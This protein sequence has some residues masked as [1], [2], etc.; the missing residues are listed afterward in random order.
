MNALSPRA[1]T[2]FRS[3]FPLRVLCAALI[4]LGAS[5]ADATDYFVSAS[6]ADAH[7][8]T[9][10]ADAWRTVT[11]VNNQ[12][13]AAGDRVFFEGGQTFSGNLYLDASEQGTAAAPIVI[14]SYGADR[15]TIY[16]DTG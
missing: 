2:V 5:R 1:S 4:L 7:S 6:G 14:G 9:S 11:R 16:A 12:R 10:P 13:L 15:A 3:S 8:G